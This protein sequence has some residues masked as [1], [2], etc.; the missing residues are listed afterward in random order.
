MYISLD[1]T[2]ATVKD[3]N[4]R[5]NLFKNMI[6][7]CGGRG[8]TEILLLHTVELNRIVL[9]Q[10][11]PSFCDHTRSD[12]DEAGVSES[13]LLQRTRLYL[14]VRQI[15]ALKARSHWGASTATATLFSVVS[16]HI[17][18]CRQWLQWQNAMQSNGLP[19]PLPLQMGIQPIQQQFPSPLFCRCRCR[20]PVRTP[21]IEFHTTHSC[22]SLPLPLPSLSVNEP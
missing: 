21:P 1:L 11:T 20:P 9:F 17:G 4:R 19:L 5:K 15:M 8:N 12:V 13:T 14:V 18:G 7:F 16:V 10:K 22:S 6:N 2:P 3:G